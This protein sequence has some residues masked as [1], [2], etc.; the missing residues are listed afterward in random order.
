MAVGIAGSLAAVGLLWQA[1]VAHVESAGRSPAVS[2]HAGRGGCKPD[3]GRLI[4]DG[5]KVLATVCRQRVQ[6]VLT[7][8][9][10]HILFPDAEKVPL[11]DGRSSQV[12]VRLASSSVDM[13]ALLEAGYVSCAASD[14]T[15]FLLTC[16]RRLTLLP[17]HQRAD[18]LRV[19]QLGR[20]VNPGVTKMAFF[21][22]L[23]FIAPVSNG[24]ECL[25]LDSE[26]PKSRSFHLPEGFANPQ[27]VQGDGELILYQAPDRQI[28]IRADKPRP[29]DVRMRMILDGDTPFP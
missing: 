28:V 17:V 2:G 13:R 10:L 25:G 29:E 24:I 18:D 22:G 20:G 19:F 11:D 23:L 12:S 15:F 16:D 1:P 26:Q 8:R 9:K 21:K 5:E 6:F 14:E 27:F 4:E 3:V 7:D